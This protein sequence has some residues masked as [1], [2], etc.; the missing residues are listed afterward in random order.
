MGRSRT[1]RSKRSNE[2]GGM[3]RPMG[4][5]ICDLTVKPSVQTQGCRIVHGGMCRPKGVDICDVWNTGAF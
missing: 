2:N 5:D 4:V 3:F 1:F